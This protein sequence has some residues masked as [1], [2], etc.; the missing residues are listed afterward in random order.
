VRIDEE[1][2]G[3]GEKENA[4]LDQ[5]RLRTRSEFN[6]VVGFK[7]DEAAGEGSGDSAQP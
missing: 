2:E 7:N 3:C 4:V 5:R 1:E 6:D